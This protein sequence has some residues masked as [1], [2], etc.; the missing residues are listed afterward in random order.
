[1]AVSIGESRSPSDTPTYLFPFLHPPFLLLMVTS[2]PFPLPFPPHHP[3]LSSPASTTNVQNDD[4]LHKDCKFLIL[5]KDNTP[6]KKEMELL[7]MT[8]DSGKVFTASPASVTASTWEPMRR[9][10]E[11][12]QCRQMS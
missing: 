11:E 3:L 2:F 4:L 8:K 12:R 5:E 9:I 1:M 10:L 6:S 7:I